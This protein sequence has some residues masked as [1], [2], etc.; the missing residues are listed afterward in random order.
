MSSNERK[1]AYMA[2]QKDYYLNADNYL[3]PFRVR[4]GV[5]IGF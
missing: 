5:G 3:D 1:G 4:F 2:S